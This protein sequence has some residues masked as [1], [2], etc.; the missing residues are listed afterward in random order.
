MTFQDRRNNFTVDKVAPRKDAAPFPAELRHAQ[1]YYLDKFVLLSSANKFYL[2]THHLDAA[3]NDL[4]R[5]KTS[6]RYKLVKEYEVEDVQSIVSASAV[7]SFYSHLAL[8][9]CSNKSVDV[10]DLNVGSSILRI[11]DAHEAKIH[12]VA[13]NQGSRHSALSSA[14][15]YNLF[16][17]ASVGVNEGVKLWDLRRPRFPV[18]MF[19]KHVNRVLP[20]CSAAFRYD[21]IMRSEKQPL[22]INKGLPQ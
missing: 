2:Y 3:K 17:T 5:Y 8:S 14:E 4:Q 22:H 12:T 6:S 10:L 11:E 20:T 9:A 15:A 16:L 18:R 7:N 1:F 19:H 21:V 13:Q